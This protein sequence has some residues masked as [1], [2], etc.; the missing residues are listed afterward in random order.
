MLSYLAARTWKERRVPTVLDRVGRAP[1]KELSN[2]DPLVAKP[3]LSVYDDRI[4][5]RG[6]RSYDH[7][8]QFQDAGKRGEKL[9]S[10][11]TLCECKEGQSIHGGGLNT[12]LG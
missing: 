5:L 8:E 12:H 2:V 10:T 3:S 6:P 1:R 7:G 4:L 9:G 11:I